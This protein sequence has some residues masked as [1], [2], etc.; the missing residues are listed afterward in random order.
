MAEVAR[1]Q[2]PI[3]QASI[4]VASQQ[5]HLGTKKLWAP[6][7]HKKKRKLAPAFTCCCPGWPPFHEC[8]LSG[9]GVLESMGL[10]DSSVYKG[11]KINRIMVR[12]GHCGMVGLFSRYG[13]VNAYTLH[14]DVS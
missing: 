2:A 5:I 13:S 6:G 1:V 10:V 4:Q 3:T 14:D 7:R 12:Q 11:D 8:L 9:Y